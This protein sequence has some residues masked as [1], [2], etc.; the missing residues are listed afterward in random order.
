MARIYVLSKYLTK[1]EMSAVTDLAKAAG[2]PAAAIKGADSVPKREMDSEDD[3]FLIL[4]NA[5]VC[6]ASDLE[7]LLLAAVDGGRRAIWIWTEDCEVSTLPKSAAKYCYSTIRWDAE[8]LRTVLSDE[9]QMIF[10]NCDGS[11]RPKIPTDR[12]LC[13]VEEKEP[14]K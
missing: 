12:N 8:H 10:E 2:V 7:E 5:A 13:V 1:K 6:V 14:P 3:G 11:P 4:G 9:D